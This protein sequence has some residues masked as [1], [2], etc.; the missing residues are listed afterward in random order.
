MRKIAPFRGAQSLGPRRVLGAH[1]Q[2]NPGGVTMSQ[3]TLEKIKALPVHDRHKLWKRAR[4]RSDDEAKRVVR[5]IEDCGLPYSE[6]AALTWDD[7]IARTMYEIISSKEAAAAMI[8]AT[9]QG[10]PAISGVDPMLR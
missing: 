1:A 3:W 7:P 5:L 8:E 10:L 6:A 9:A 4:D 2:A